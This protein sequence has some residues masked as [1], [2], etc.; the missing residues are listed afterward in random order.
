MCKFSCLWQ[1]H[2]PT[3][4]IIPAS[5]KNSKEKI[6]NGAEG[7]RETVVRKATDKRVV[8]KA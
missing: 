4:Y 8:N 6:E 1:V 5:L 2:T 3:N 7:K